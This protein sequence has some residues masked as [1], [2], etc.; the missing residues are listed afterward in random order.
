MG[1]EL[2]RQ[3]KAYQFFGSSAQASD[4][5]LAARKYI[6]KGHVYWQGN[7]R[8]VT[9][10]MKNSLSTAKFVKATGGTIVVLSACVTLYQAGS[11]FSDGQYKSGSA[12]IA[13]A[14][15]AAGAVF[16]PGVGWCVSIGIGVADAFWGDDF[17]NW[18]EN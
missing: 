13:V 5:A 2:I 14:A 8:G 10:S 12:R 11:D 6:H 9:N 7:Y 3:G 17:Y 4:E 16:I 15:I 1:G 18:L